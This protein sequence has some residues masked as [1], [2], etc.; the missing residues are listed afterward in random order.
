MKSAAHKPFARAAGP[1]Y[2]DL[3]AAFGDW[4]Q[5]R[6]SPHFNS[7]LAYLLQLMVM[8]FFLFAKRLS[9]RPN[10]KI[11]TGDNCGDGGSERHAAGK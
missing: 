1:L 7:F 9:S 11:E 3:A 5:R 6:S 8:D 4:W 2:Q 10:L